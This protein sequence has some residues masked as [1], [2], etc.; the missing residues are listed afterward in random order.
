MGSPQKQVSVAM[1]LHR[2]DIR[3]DMR[4]GRPAG[5]AEGEAVVEVGRR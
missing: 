5:E 2:P 4:G 1:S 3:D